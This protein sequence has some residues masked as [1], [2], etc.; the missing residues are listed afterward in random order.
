MLI[1]FIALALLF[2]FID[3]FEGHYKIHYLNTTYGK[4]EPVITLMTYCH[5]E[6]S[7]FMATYSVVF[8]LVKRGELLKTC[9]TF[10][11]VCKTL[12]ISAPAIQAK[13]RRLRWSFWFIIVLA[14]IALVCSVV[15]PHFWE[16]F[17]H[18]R[19]YGFMILPGGLISLYFRG[20]MFYCTLI[21]YLMHNLF[22]YFC[23]LLLVCSE[24]LRQQQAEFL[25]TLTLKPDLKLSGIKFEDRLRIWLGQNELLKAQFDQ[26][27]K[28]FSW[29][30]LLDVGCISLAICMQ[31]AWIS[32]WILKPG[33]DDFSLWTVGTLAQ[34]LLYTMMYLF[35][36]WVVL[37]RPLMLHQLHQQ[38]SDLLEK[39]ICSAQTS[40]LKNAT[41]AEV[42][43]TSVLMH[44]FSTS[45][46]LFNA[47]GIVTL[48]T[49]V[50]CTISAAIFAFAW[51]ILD[52]SLAY[53]P[54]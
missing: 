28:T 54:T 2:D 24:D 22:G 36:G 53:R 35:C 14:I 4:T 30:L 46:L 47:G 13:L 19:P 41:R 48:G 20:I 32:T 45:Q 10:E 17:Y 33:M 15:D 31:L 25:E 40:G 23:D 3:V 12:E 44:R 52:R 8:L 42:L 50:L 9:L 16:T 27:Q 7:L 34:H 1:A 43:L 21:H 51:F 29:K 37:F 5:S 38:R 11:E 39:I 26:V 49:T 6:M 18:A